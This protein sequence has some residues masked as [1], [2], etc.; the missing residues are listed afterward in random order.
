M[1]PPQSPAIYS[2][3]SHPPQAPGAEIAEC[4]LTQ[5][6]QVDPRGWVPTNG[7][8]H[9]KGYAEAFGV[10]ALNHILDIRDTLDNERFV[11][12]GVDGGKE[13]DGRKS[14]FSEDSAGMDS[15][16]IELDSDASLSGE[17]GRGAKR[18]LERLE[19]IDSKRN[20]PPAHI[21]NN[22]LLV[23]SLLTPLFADF[24]SPGEAAKKR[25]ANKV[26]IE[27]FPPPTANKHWTYANVS[28]FKVRGKTYK[29]DKVKVQADKKALF[30]FMALDVIETDSPMMKGLCGHP[31]QRVMQALER[32]KQGV[33]GACPPY[34]VC[35]NIALPGPPFYHAVF[36]YAVEDMSMIDGTNGTEFSKL[37]KPFFFGDDD[38]M[39]DKTFK[40]I[41]Q[42]VEGNFIVRRA[43]GSTPA[44][45]GTKL[46]QTYRRHE[47]YFE[48]ICDVGSSSVA[49]GVLRLA[50]GYART[51][52]VDMVFLLEGKD[53]STLPEKVFGSARVSNLPFD[54]PDFAFVKNY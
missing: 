43:V 44:I 22:L 25:A 1:E 35:V 32:E 41:P 17:I 18:R 5:I 48:L 2:L 40:L 7:S 33:E 54:N 45:L 3:P 36:Y 16:G 21:T 49:A 30:K 23:T 13:L 12:V 46:K 51:L 6:V 15:D 9:V 20:T 29:S 37:A 10:E 8:R 34:V 19:R 27:N 4:L 39:R 28:N 14:Q 26:T 11:N 31:S 53:E 47:R 38:E 50:I 42:I 24:T 52:V